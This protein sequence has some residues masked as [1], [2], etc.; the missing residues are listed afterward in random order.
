[1]YEDLI[2][3]AMPRARTIA[4]KYRGA[5]DPDEA[6]GVA[7]FTLVE[8]APRFDSAR[9]VKFA[10]FVTPRIIGALRDRM[11]RLPLVGG[12]RD[13]LRDIAVLTLDDLDNPVSVK[14]PLQLEDAVLAKVTVRRAIASMRSASQPLQNGRCKAVATMLADGWDNLSIRDAMG[15]SDSLMGQSKRYAFERMRIALTTRKI[16]SV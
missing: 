8:N 11:R 7:W 9:G 12:S 10:A 4:L 13:A 5:L 15:I 1:M 2:V 6:I 14:D 16:R 3:S